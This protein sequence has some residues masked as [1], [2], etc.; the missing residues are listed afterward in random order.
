MS[1]YY[2]HYSANTYEYDTIYYKDEN[3]EFINGPKG[4]AMEVYEFDN[5]GQKILEN[6]S[7]HGSNNLSFSFNKSCNKGDCNYFNKYSFDKINCTTAW[8]YSEENEAEISP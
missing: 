2:N 6:V 3:D 7:N 1:T 4:F 5:D 8:T